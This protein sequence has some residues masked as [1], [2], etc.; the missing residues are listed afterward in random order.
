MLATL[1]TA[2]NEQPLFSVPNLVIFIVVAAVFYPIQKKIRE[3]VSRRRRERW[4]EEE[5]LTEQDG[6]PHD[7]P[8]GDTQP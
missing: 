5:Q 8:A 6:E 1:L 3:T 4:A 7:R 2:T